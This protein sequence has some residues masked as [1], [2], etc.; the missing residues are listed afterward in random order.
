M[1]SSTSSS[2]PEGSVRAPE[3]RWGAICASALV[4]AT[5]GV[6]ANEARWRAQGQRATV[7]DDHDLWSLERARASDGETSTVVLLGH[8]RMMLGFEPSVFRE[9]FPS[10]TLANIA[11]QASPPLASLRDLAA[12]P[13][14]R[15]V[16]LVEI[17]ER[18]FQPVYVDAQEPRVRHYHEVFG[19]ARAWDRRLTTFVQ[20]HVVST[21]PHVSL[22]RAALF[23]SEIEPSYTV[24]RP[25]RSRPADYSLVDTRA[26]SNVRV[27]SWGRRFDEHPPPPPADWLALTSDTERWVATI[28]E[29]GVQ[30]AFVRFPTSGALLELEQRIWPKELYWDAWSART[31]AVAIHFL[32]VPSLARFTC[33]EDSHLDQRDAPAFTA[34][35][36]DEL[37]AR[38]VLVR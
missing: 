15:G 25:D 26:L 27:E 34:A 17:S 23:E 6:A 4:L 14:F 13:D 12:D 3:K 32:D 22:L 11:V 16:A 9:R 24:L 1:R 28:Q 33:P 30:V 2:E 5:V 7:V 21:N 18:A 10:R 31:R 29:R 38:G 35:L 8:S 20:W 36:L 37:E 19:P